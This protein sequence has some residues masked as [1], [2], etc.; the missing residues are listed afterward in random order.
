MQSLIEKAK[1]AFDKAP[2]EIKVTPSIP[3]L[4]FGDYEAY[5]RSTTRIVTV[6]LN[7][8]LNEFPEVKPFRRFPN[9]EISYTD[10]LNKYFQN[11]PYDEWFSTFDYLLKGFE[12][13]FYGNSKNTALHT[14]LF[15]PVATDPTWSGLNERFRNELGNFGRPLWRELI[16]FLK[17]HIILISIAEKYCENITF[18]FVQRWKGIF[19]IPRSRP[20]VIKHAIIKISE[21]SR[22]DLLFGQ[23]AQKPFGT[24]S[25]EIKETI[26]KTLKNKLSNW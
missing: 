24:L 9:A 15:S 2:A 13:G 21:D 14:D 20:Y 17:P 25:N 6:G 19:T 7:P 16:K 5:S 22:A 12:A 3:I 4:Y 23:A 26:G 18:E 1:V 11:C 8:S 10:A